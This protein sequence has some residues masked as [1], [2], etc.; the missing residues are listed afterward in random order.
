MRARIASLF[1][2]GAS[3]LL[4]LS[5]SG[6]APEDAGA[7]EDLA[8]EKPAEDPG[9]TDH[10]LRQRI[11]FEGPDNQDFRVDAEPLSHRARKWHAYP[12]TVFPGAVIGAKLTVHDPRM[13]LKAQIRLWGPA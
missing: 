3:L 12:L 6:C 2:L 4:A 8:N 7:E 5:A 11:L 9:S 10:V 1:A 13:S